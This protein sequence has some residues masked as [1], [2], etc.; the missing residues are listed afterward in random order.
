MSRQFIIVN[1]GMM[2]MRGH[3]FETAISTAEAARDAGFRPLLAVH[4][5]CPVDALPS[6]LDCLPLFRVD[7]WGGNARFH[8]LERHGIRGDRA[9][10]LNAPIDVVSVVDYL[11]AR[12][13]P[14]PEPPRLR[15]RLKAILKRWAPAGLI[16]FLKR[17]AN[18]KAEEIPEPEDPER[19]HEIECARLFA[20]D[21]EYLLCLRNVGADDLVFM[22]TANHREVYAVRQL[23]AKIGERRVPRFHLEFR[24]EIAERGNLEKEMRPAILRETRFAKLFFD[25]C[26][27]TSGSPGDRLSFW[28]DTEELADDY[29][30]LSDYAFGVLPIPFNHSLIENHPTPGQP[31]LKCLYLGDVRDEKGFH[32]L[33]ELIRALRDDGT[34]RFVVQATRPHPAGLTPAVASA[35]GNLEALESFDPDLLQLVGREVAFLPREQYFRLLG[36]SDIVL[37]LYD[38]KTYRAR[39]SGIMAEAISAGKPAIVP[40]G[41][42]MEHQLP[43][44]CGE[45]FVDMPSLVAAVRK[46]AADY[47]RYHANVQK[48][49]AAW[50]SKHSPATLLQRLLANETRL[51]EAA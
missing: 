37:C 12:Y 43:G 44:G 26:R 13:D 39:S 51:K 18:A 45:S 36:D 46:I 49:R 17:A 7:H 30:Q 32:R 23:I 28:T 22:P 42:W 34:I 25:L 27:E 2:E 14:L 6:W 35:L 10:M 19:H 40:A 8:P 31:P 9:A 50:L 5:S 20:E 15:Q 1:N 16:R 29:R 3:Y 33:P 48:L 41:T 24:H 47:P 38:A 11:K 21:L 4:E